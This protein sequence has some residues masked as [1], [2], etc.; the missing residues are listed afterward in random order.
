MGQ[1]IAQTPQGF[2]LTRDTGLQFLHGVLNGNVEER[3]EV[4]TELS[5]VL[6]HEGSSISGITKAGQQSVEHTL[7]SNP[8]R[9][10]DTQDFADGFSVLQSRL[11]ILAHSNSKQVHVLLILIGLRDDRSEHTS[12]S[13]SHLPNHGEFQTTESLAEQT[14]MGSSS[15]NR[16]VV[17][18]GRGNQSLNS[19]RESRETVG[20]L[21][22]FVCKRLHGG[23]EIGHLPSELVNVCLFQFLNHGGE[24]PKLIDKG[25]QIGLSKLGQRA[26]TVSKSGQ[27]I[28]VRPFQVVNRTA[29]CRQLIGDRAGNFHIADLTQGVQRTGNAGDLLLNISAVQA[30][31]SIFQLS[32]ALS[33]TAQTGSRSPASR[34]Q[35]TKGIPQ[36]FQTL[37]G[38]SAVIDNLKF[39]TLNFHIISHLRHHLSLEISCWSQWQRL[40]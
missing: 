13:P 40:P 15:P 12:D 38:L 30:L 29:D 1:V 24:L 3:T 2:Q 19:G 4:I 16:A 14:R 10:V 18:L 27:L 35:T 32:H 31:Q 25:G 6:A 20:H 21:L 34:S 8:V 28:A 23:S 9:Q 36:S 5:Q 7:I 11:G 26:Q 33:S 37:L 17:P 22:H 39:Q